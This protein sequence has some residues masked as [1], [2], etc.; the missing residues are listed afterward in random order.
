M[1]KNFEYMSVMHSYR[2]FAINASNVYNIYTCFTTHFI[3]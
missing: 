1:L 2:K 3:Y